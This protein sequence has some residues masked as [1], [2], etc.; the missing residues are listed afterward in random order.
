MDHKVFYWYS[1][2][3]RI[4]CFILFFLFV[5]ESTR[6]FGNHYV[7]YR[8]LGFNKAYSLYPFYVIASYILRS[9]S[10]SVDLSSRLII[11]S[12]F[13]KILQ[14]S[15]HSFVQSLY[16]HLQFQKSIFPESFANFRTLQ[17]FAQNTISNKIAPFI[18][19]LLYA[20]AFIFFVY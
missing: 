3:P 12:T 1:L 10:S 16:K 4:E 6:R 8:F 7:L 2:Q 11:Y 17:T 20:F 13:L 18:V 19:K 14:F 15:S 9:F 5:V